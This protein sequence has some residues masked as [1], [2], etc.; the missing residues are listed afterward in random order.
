MLPQETHHHLLVRITFETR[1]D[2]QRIEGTTRTHG[3]MAHVPALGFVLLVYCSMLQ[4]MGVEAKARA[5][6]ED[7]VNT[8]TS[9]PGTYDKKIFVDDEKAMLITQVSRDVWGG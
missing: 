7:R 6:E 9:M 3:S 5:T 1:T 2:A 8:T 4:Q